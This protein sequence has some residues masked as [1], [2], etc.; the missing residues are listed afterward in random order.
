[1]VYQ[2]IDI[3]VVTKN[4]DTEIRGLEYVPVNNLIIETSKPLGMARMRAIQKV[5][6]KWFAF[7]DDDVS[8]DPCWF[9]SLSPKITPEL[10]AISGYL[11]DYGFNREV[12]YEL[13]HL[14]IPPRD[15][16][17]GER[18]VGTHSGLIR[19]EAVRDWRPSRPDLSSWE[20]YDITQH[21]LRK[22][23]K[24][25]R[26]PKYLGTHKKGWDKIVKNS[27]WN[28]VGEIQ[29]KGRL[30]AVLNTLRGIVQ[31]FHVL[32]LPSM[33]WKV[34]QFYIFCRYTRVL[35]LVRLI[36]Q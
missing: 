11:R 27:M 3:C 9:S 1:V 23:Y 32:V 26:V 22:G 16:K 24:V 35:N 36:T 19:T 31:I 7:I 13:A 25:I 5:T 21:I 8:L 15:Y 4:K 28:L 10:G 29:M 2:T 18:W 30:S 34:K 6:T 33:N 14:S 12:D 17:I 20:D